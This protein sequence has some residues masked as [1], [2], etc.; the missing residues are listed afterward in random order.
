MEMVLRV[1]MKMKARGDE[2]G[3]H[4]APA[5]GVEE[6]APRREAPRGGRRRRQ[7]LGAEAPCP[8]FFFGDGGDVDGFLPL[9]GCC[10]EGGIS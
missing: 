7:P 8:F 4:C 10:Q 5:P 9:L 2:V 1:L 6:A 3:G